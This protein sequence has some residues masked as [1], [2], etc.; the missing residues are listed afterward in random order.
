MTSLRARSR[1]LFW[2]VRAGAPLDALDRTRRALLLVRIR[3]SAAWHRSTVDVDLAS[4]V[5]IG[6]DVRVWVTPRTANVLHVGAGSRLG[7]RVLIQLKGGQVRIGPGCDLRRDTVLNVAGRLD[8]E[9]R[10]ILSWGCAIHC[11]ESVVL[12]PMASAAEHV[13]IADSTHY[14]TEPDRFFYD[15]IRS[16]PVR[17][18]TNTWLCPK[19]TVTSGTSI[20][21]HCIIAS[22]SVVTG[23]VP[24]GSLASGVPVADIRPLRLPWRPAA[25]APGR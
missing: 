4:D 5:H 8:L 17:I 15:N 16:A 21:S 18:G 12:E 22:N 24:D 2:I 23:D 1:W 20:G 10:N 25:G 11:A 13:S 19:S 7:D 9:G 6:R 3:A 14:F